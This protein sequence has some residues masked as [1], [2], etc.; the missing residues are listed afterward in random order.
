MNSTGPRARPPI[1]R[2]HL[3][4]ASLEHGPSTMA[5]LALEL[6]VS[7]RTIQRDIEFMRDRLNL[8]IE[9]DFLGCHLTRKV[10]QC[11]T[12]AAKL[13]SGVWHLGSGVRLPRPKTQDAKPKSLN[14]HVDE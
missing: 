10:C 12:C 14:G 8:P 5:R 11:E 3:I 9:C 6:E 4:V 1:E 13:G 7:K 2:F